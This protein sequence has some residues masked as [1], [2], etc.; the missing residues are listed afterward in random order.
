MFEAL[1]VGLPFVGTAVGGV[2]EIITSED[3]GLLYPPKDPKCLAEK[4]LIALEKDWDREKIRK[5]AEQFTWENIAKKIINIYT[6]VIHNEW[7]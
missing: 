3:Y 2:P 7:E 5:Y 6:Q 4:I 1:G